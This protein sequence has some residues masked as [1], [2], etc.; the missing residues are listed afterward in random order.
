[1]CFNH[2]LNHLP[3]SMEKLFSMKPVSGAKKAGDPCLKKYNT[4]AQ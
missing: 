3:L 1:M 4:S 2:P